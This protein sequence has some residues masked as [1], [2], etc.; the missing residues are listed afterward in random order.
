MKYQIIATGSSGNAVV[1]NGDILIDC[2]VSFKALKNVYCNLKIVLLTHKHSDHLNKTTIK[3]LSEERPTL[4]FGCCEWLVPLL[5]EIGIPIINIDVYK[6]GVIYDY[7]AFK[8]STVK[9]YHDVPNCGYRVFVDNEKAIYCTDTR[10]LDG[11]S[12]KNYDLFLIEANYGE[13][14]IK[15]RIKAKQGKQYVYEVRVVNTH[16]S[17]EQASEFILNNM[18]FNNSEY[19]LLHCHK[20]K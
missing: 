11:I 14:E 18:G 10:T 16:L 20:E 12:A 3:K 17:E 15:E 13:N 5:V 19:V 2:G 9:L 8:I 1:L 4:R 6:I 7:R